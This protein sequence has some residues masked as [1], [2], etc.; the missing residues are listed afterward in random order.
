MLALTASFAP[1]ALGRP[2]QLLEE[3][4]SPAISPANEL[5][6]NSLLGR[7]Y[8]VQDRRQDLSPNLLAATHPDT[9]SSNTA[10]RL[11]PY[12]KFLA[13][14]SDEPWLRL[15][16]RRSD[17]MDG[18]VNY[19]SNVGTYSAPKPFVPPAPPVPAPPPAVTVRPPPTVTPPTLPSA[20]TTRVPSAKSTLDKDTQ[21]KHASKA[22]VSKKVHKAARTE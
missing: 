6:P 21:K 5:A 12:A 17:D 16:E 14:R 18:N 7:H 3:F 20:A 2:T 19:L 15:R 11:V 1:A 9:S 10:R 4:M 8:S 22:K 13:D